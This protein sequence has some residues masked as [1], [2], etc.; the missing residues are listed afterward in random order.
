MT[1]DALEKP[2]VYKVGFLRQLLQWI[3][4]IV[5]L[6]FFI[7]MPVM[8][9][10]RAFHGRIFD[11]LWL[12]I[13]AVLFAITLIFLGLQIQA[14]RRTRIK[15][16]NDEVDIVVPNWRGPTPFAPFDE[17]KLPYNKIEA[18]EQ[19][20]EIYRSLGILGLRKV[21][22]VV[23]SDGDR[24][25]LGY[26]TEQ[27]SDAPIP[28]ATVAETVAQRAG[29][30]LVD[31]GAVNVGTQIAAAFKGTPDW[32]TDPIE[33]EDVE[34]TRKRAKLIFVGMI[35]GFFVLVGAGMIIALLPNIMAMVS[36]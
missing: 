15:V 9:G 11:A 1:T 3:T 14:A 8:I 18:V 24:Y 7:S 34:A 33:E 26:S 10:M 21:S 25:V 31:R 29:V 32:D 35:V 12:T 23:T 30:Q 27:E 20:G 13:V 16:N 22:S 2:M 17:A 36:R 4:F 6:P 28:F 5:L 19:R